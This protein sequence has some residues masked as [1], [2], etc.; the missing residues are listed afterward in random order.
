MEIAAETVRISLHRK[1]ANYCTFNR[2]RNFLL[3]ETDK[4]MYIQYI[5]TLMRMEA[6]KI[7]LFDDVQTL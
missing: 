7:D 4:Y 2:G 5:F 3:C 6:Q 1:N